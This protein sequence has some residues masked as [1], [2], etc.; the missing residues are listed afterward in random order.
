MAKEDELAHTSEGIP[1]GGSYEEQKLD[2]LRK[3][4]KMPVHDQDRPGKVKQR[5][6]EGYEEI[7]EEDIPLSDRAG[8]GRVEK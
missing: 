8:E 6:S 2:E 3:D 4:G 5:T 1:V 7:D